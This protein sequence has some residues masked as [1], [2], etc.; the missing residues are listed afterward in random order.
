M[1]DIVLDFEPKVVQRVKESVWH[2]QQV[3][4]ELPGGRLRLTLRLNSTLEI[5]P[6][7]LSW[8]PYVKVINPPELRDSIAD[9]AR[10]MAANYATG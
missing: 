3:L 4:Q 6:W 1:V 5:A 8:G 7:I 2:P 9:T 10:R